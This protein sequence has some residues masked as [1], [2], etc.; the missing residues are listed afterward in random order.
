[1]AQEADESERK[2]PLGRAAAIGLTKADIIDAGIAL[3]DEVGLQAFSIRELARRLGVYPAAV[4]WHVGGAKDDLFGEMTARITTALL[5]PEEESEDWRETIRMLF[6][7]FRAAS[8][9]HPHLVALMGASMKSNGPPHAGLVEVVLRALARAGHEGQPAIDWFNALIGG[10]GGFMT[11]ELAPAPTAELEA[12]RRSFD[13]GLD[14]L[15]AAEFPHTVAAL[16]LMRN[17]AFALRWLNGVDVP[18]DGGFERLLDALILGI[19][20][21]GQPDG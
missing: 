11:M 16:P 2:Q 1:M 18:L 6:R 4:Y 10:I 3:I 7:R 13:E 5:R 15:D 9:A 19:E 17:R 20:R 21:S 12:W 14:R 8:Q